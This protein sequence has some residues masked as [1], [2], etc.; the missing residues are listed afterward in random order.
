MHKTGIPQNVRSFLF[1]HGFTHILNI[2]VVLAFFDAK[3]IG[4]RNRHQKPTKYSENQTIFTSQHQIQQASSQTRL[5]SLECRRLLSFK[6]IFLKNKSIL[7]TNNLSTNFSQF[8]QLKKKIFIDF[9]Q[10]GQEIKR[11]KK[12]SFL[13]CTYSHLFNKRAVANNVQVGTISKI[14]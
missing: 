6:E 4:S 9:E 11:R 13:K 2:S 10:G 8:K 7:I 12:F 3:C 1:C 14:K 5:G